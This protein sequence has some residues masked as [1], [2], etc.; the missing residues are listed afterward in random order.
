M[1]RNFYCMIYLVFD[2]SPTHNRKYNKNYVFKIVATC[3]HQDVIDL[4]QYCP[5]MTCDSILD[6]FVSPHTSRLSS[7]TKSFLTFP[8][9]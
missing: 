2:L 8:L 5:Y 9:S 1:L 4:L 3:N 6:C 7:A